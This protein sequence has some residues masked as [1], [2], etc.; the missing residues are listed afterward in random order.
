M[1]HQK[2][3]SHL[4]LS[5][6]SRVLES[7]VLPARMNL[8]FQ[9]LDSAGQLMGGYA[10][11]CQAFLFQEADLVNQGIHLRCFEQSRLFTPS[12]LELEES[13]YEGGEAGFMVLAVEPCSV[14]SPKRI[15]QGKIKKT[16]TRVSL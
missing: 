6:S 9:L 7:T 2:F 11:A 13:A 4:F 5:L 8:L 3:W 16:S 1:L 10:H 12:S 15:F 14:P